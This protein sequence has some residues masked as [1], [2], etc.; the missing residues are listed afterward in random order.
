[1]PPAR[2]LP[3][4]PPITSALNSSAAT[5]ATVAENLLVGAVLVTAILLAFLRNLRAAVI[6]AAV[7]PCRCCSPS[8]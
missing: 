8:S 5:V 6:V 4:A 1:M 7:I 2:R 3:P